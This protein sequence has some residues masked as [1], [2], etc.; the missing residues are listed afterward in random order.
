[1]NAGDQGERLR[2]PAALSDPKDKQRG[3]ADNR[4]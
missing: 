3:L 2:G 1:M 4:G